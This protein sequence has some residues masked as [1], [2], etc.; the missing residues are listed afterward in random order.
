MSTF[1]PPSNHKEVVSDDM[2]C[3]FGLFIQMFRVHLPEISF[4][5]NRRMDNNLN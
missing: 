3:S 2:I 4:L 1:M 5:Q